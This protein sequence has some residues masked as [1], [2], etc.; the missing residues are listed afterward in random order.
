MRTAGAVRTYHDEHPGIAIAV[1]DGGVG[2]GV[3]D[4]LR[5]MDVPVYEVK[6]GGSPD[7]GASV[8]FKNKLAEIYWA[9]REHLREK[10][11]SLPNDAKLWAQLT[12][13]E[14]AQESDRTIRVYKRGK[15]N[16]AP[17]PDRAD[18][19]ALALEARA[20]GEHGVG[21]WL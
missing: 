9:L 14:W 6:L 10:R 3:V 4:R 1:D 21:L 2:G 7:G 8:H 15:E 5:E 12:Q 19:L 16:H 20:R 18:A 13:I 11:L 17:S